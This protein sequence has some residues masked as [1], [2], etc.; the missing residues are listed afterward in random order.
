MNVLSSLSALFAAAFS[1]QALIVISVD[2]YT[3]ERYQAYL[4]ST[5]QSTCDRT[6]N[7]D[8]CGHHRSR[9]YNQHFHAIHASLPFRCRYSQLKI[10]T[11]E[12][13]HSMC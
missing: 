11:I 5:P 4:V 10:F 12:L 13:I 1:L 8:H 7:T 9:R 2:G 6:N 3:A